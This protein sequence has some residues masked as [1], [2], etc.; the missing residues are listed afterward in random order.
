MTHRKQIRTG[1]AA[2][3]FVAVAIA[4]S[5]CASPTEPA[6]YEEKTGGNCVIFNGQ[7]YCG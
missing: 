2:A 4:L 6:G 3:L 1:V 7:W 5:G